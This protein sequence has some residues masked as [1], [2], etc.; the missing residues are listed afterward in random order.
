MKHLTF[1]QIITRIVIG[2]LIAGGSIGVFGFNFFGIMGFLL[3]MY[4]IVTSIGGYDPILNDW[5]WMNK[6]TKDED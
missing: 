2:A 3:G 5:N 6:R 4:G 1:F